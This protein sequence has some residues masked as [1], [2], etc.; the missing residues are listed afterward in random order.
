MRR[1]IPFFAVAVLAISFG[2]IAGWI[3]ASIQIAD[4]VDRIVAMSWGDGRGGPSYYGAQV[5]L[6]PVTSGYS[7]KARVLIGR[8]DGYF[9][10]CGV[11]GTAQT[12]SAAVA[13]WGTIDWREDGLHIGSGANH[14]FLPRAELESH[15]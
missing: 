15:R 2:F 13:K 12:D 7:V 3:W 4:S 5:Y 6:E 8:G 14:F 10:N 11:L 1:F 9:H